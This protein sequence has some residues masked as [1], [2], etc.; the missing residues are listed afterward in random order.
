MMNPSDLLGKV[1]AGYQIQEFIDAGG[2]ATVYKA[3]YLAPVDSSQSDRIEPIYAAVKVYKHRPDE[4]FSRRFRRALQEVAYLQNID[5]SFVARVINIQEDGEYVYIL[6]EWVDG[7]SI[8]NWLAGKTLPK[9]EIQLD[10]AIQIVE[11]VKAIHEG[12]NGRYVHGDLTP[13]NIMIRRDNRPKI[14]DFGLARRAG[15]DRHSGSG[16]MRYMAPELLVPSEA[17]QTISQ[18]ADIYSLG[19]VLFYLFTGSFYLASL[20]NIDSHTPTSQ[21]QQQQRIDQVI[22][23]KQNEV[24][25]SILRD[26]VKNYEVLEKLNA[27][28]K[29]M[30]R[31]NPE[32]RP[33]IVEVT[34]Y[35]KEIKDMMAS[36]SSV[37]DR[38]EE[39]FRNVNI[40]FLI[41]GTMSRYNMQWMGT[42]LDYALHDIRHHYI[43]RNDIAFNY[44]CVFYGEYQNLPNKQRGKTIIPFEIEYHP[45]SDYE[46]LGLFLN[47]LEAKLTS[48]DYP[49]EAFFYQDSCN[50]L[51]LGLEKVCQLVKGSEYTYPRDMIIVN[52]LGTSPPH[53][54]GKEREK[55]QL[56]DWTSDEFEHDLDWDRFLKVL[57][58][59][60]KA[61]L[62]SFWIEPSTDDP[63]MPPETRRF[64][65]YVWK[66]L[67]D[68]KDFWMINDEA[69]GEWCLH[70]W[71]TGLNSL[72]KS[73]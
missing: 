18:K 45:F 19:A 26:E 24:V 73:W 28:V 46:H 60:Y 61:K 17:G 68:R 58:N 33:T 56:L 9:F 10:I 47:R 5:S 67:N 4:G 37:R 54:T 52:I 3:T 49:K 40:V 25:R 21:R 72:L 39:V 65:E 35:F 27:L 6:M 30:L 62:F 34:K 53:P 42:F 1:V 44:A 69:S 20:E 23:A 66:T 57:R 15:I 36:R 14:I 2:Q 41:D 16:T 22:Q 31:V 71:K 8:E 29:A 32:E 48:R 43:Q 12:G 7:D 38:T 51:E 64:A 59:E 13:R 50:A 70:H 11:G 55:F 63:F